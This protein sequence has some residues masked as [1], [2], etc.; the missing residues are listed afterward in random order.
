MFV[1][2]PPDCTPLVEQTRNWPNP[3][4]AEAM[5][6]FFQLL[7][8]RMDCERLNQAG[9]STIEAVA[10]AG[11]EVRRASFEEGRL[12]Y[13]VPAVVLERSPRGEVEVRL[14]IDRPARIYSAQVPAEV[15]RDLTSRDAVAQQTP[16]PPGPSKPSPVYACHGWFVTLEAAESRGSWTRTA[17]ECQPA[18]GPAVAYG[19]QLA[20]IAITH[21]PQCTAAKAEMAGKPPAEDN[22]LWALIACAGRVGIRT[23][24]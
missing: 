20:E 22:A 21:I 4:S 8:Q 16:P 10:D 23:L 9:W 6:R 13:R 3:S 18:D 7:T 15:W 1:D 24:D 12:T 11:Q 2:Q 14:S 17:H 5:R 19:I